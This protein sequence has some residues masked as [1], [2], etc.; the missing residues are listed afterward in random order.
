MVDGAR[1]VGNA[2]NLSK[3]SRAGKL[4]LGGSLALPNYGRYMSS[5]TPLP[6]GSITTSVQAAGMRSDWPRVYD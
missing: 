6:R 4:R 1:I 5:S 3:A 2:G